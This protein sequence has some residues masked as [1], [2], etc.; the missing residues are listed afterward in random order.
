M[1]TGYPD[2][3]ADTLICDA[4]SAQTITFARNVGVRS[5]TL[6]GDAYEPSETISGGAAL[7]GAE[8]R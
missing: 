4:A 1:L 6:D 7:L 2:E 3:V 8:R 5:V